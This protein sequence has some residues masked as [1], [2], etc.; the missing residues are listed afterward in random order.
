M[1]DAQIAGLVLVGGGGHARSIADVAARRGLRVLAVVDPSGPEGW[2]VPVF[3]SLADLAESFATASFVVAIGDN[4]VR[5]REAAAIDSQGRTHGVLVAATATVA[6]QVG[7]GTQILEHAHVGP[8]ARVGRGVIVNT[9]AVVEHDVVVG[10][11]AHVAP[12]A[13]LLGAAQVGSGALIGARA[14]VLP[15]VNVGA[16]AVVG[17]GSVVVRDVPPGAVVTGVPARRQ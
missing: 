9:S 14:V 11:Y 12:G 1:P 3:A 15:S 8:G 17:A 2:D 7:D 13:T 10:D 16:G 6:P 4:A 5:A